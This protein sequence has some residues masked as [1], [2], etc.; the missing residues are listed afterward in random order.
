MLLNADT[1]IT[2]SPTPP[3]RGRAVAMGSPRA[4]SSGTSVPG[5]ANQ[6]GLVW[7]PAVFGPQHG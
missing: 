1:S 3:Q 7:H 5:W 4:M 2:V 6:G